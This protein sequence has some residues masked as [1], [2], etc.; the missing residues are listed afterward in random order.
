MC[1]HWNGEGQIFVCAA[2]TTKPAK[3]NG[4]M[5]WNL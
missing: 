1:I 4:S 3:C 5:D 2:L